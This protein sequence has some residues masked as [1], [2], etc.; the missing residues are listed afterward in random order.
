M[1][2]LLYRLG[3]FSARRAWAVIGAWLLIL[4]ATVGLML[5]AGGKLSS[6]ISIDGVPS[7]LVIDQLQKSFPEASRASGQVIFHKAD[8]T[9]FTKADRTAIAAALADVKNLD[10]VAD[11]I[12]PFDVE[13]QIADRRAEVTDG[14]EQLVDGEKKIADGRKEI[15]ANKTKLADGLAKLNAAQKDLETQSAQLEAGIKQAQAAGAPQTQ[16]DALIANRAKIAG[17]FAEIKKQRAV[18]VAGQAKLTAAEA[19]LNTAEQELT[20]A[21]PQLT[22]A[23]TILKTTENYSTVS[24]DNTVALATIQFTVSNNELE[25]PIREGVVSSLANAD[26]NGVQV[27]F[28]QELTRSISEILGVG[29]IIGLAIAAVVL[30]IM[31]GTLI[32]A[33]MP[34]ILAV[35]GVG[36]SASITM[37]LASVIDMTSTTPVLGVMLGL[38]VGIDYALFI[39]NRH[40]R[41]L[42]AGV[43]V[44][45]SIGLATGT[46]GNAVL[47]AGLTVI[48]ALAALNLTGIDFIGLMGSMG[49]ISIAFA[50]LLAITATPAALSLIGMRVLSKKERA[51]LGTKTAKKQPKKLPAPKDAKQP[52]WATKHPWVS[53]IATVAVLIIAAL[54]FSSM[55]LGLPD[56]AS[57]P[58]E[59][60]PNKA[61]VLTSDAFGPGFNGQ[62][63]TVLSMPNAVAKDDQVALQAKVSSELFGLDNVDA[64]VPAKIS[65]DAKTFLFQVVPAIEPSSAETE[66]LVTDIRALNAKYENEL[67]ASIGVTGLTAANIDISEKINSVLPLYLGTVLALSL[68]L[69]ILVFRSILIPVIAAVGFLLTVFATL[70][71]VVAVYQWGWAADLLGVPNPGP[72]L[73]FLPIFLIGILFGLAM[74]YQLFL[75]SG[76]R[77]AFSHGKSPKDAINYGIHLSRA[78][79]IAAALIMITV[80]GGFAFSHL[81]MIRPVGFGLAAGVIFDAFIVRLIFVPAAMTLLGKAAWWIPGWL[82]RVLPDVD[83]EGTKLEREHLH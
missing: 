70:G 65:D 16:I 34:V 51:T 45:E 20:D 14:A 54:P 27:E 31:L 1:A 67:N 47:F 61:Y 6:S 7:Q 79:V 25:E 15:A 36:I 48:I 52:V 35:V 26:L 68:V 75:V 81:T 44:H 49:S 41:Q 23:Q 74:D 80:F 17:G 2:A 46:S 55:R 38:A 32:G 78:V 83:V 13:K 22:D 12:D 11:A 62:I 19:K 3:Q 42:K 40:R 18:I 33:G 57:E 69:L 21:Q 50:V 56:G 71:T 66:K 58:K 28:S 5:T 9:E 60:S 8:G 53:V 73:S 64:V 59:S 24:A 4:A 43:D 82:D 29:E 76:M 63:S 30:F 72:I 10:G 39:L 77:E 37:A